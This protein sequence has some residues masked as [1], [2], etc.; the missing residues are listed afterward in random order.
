MKINDI[1]EVKIIGIDHYGRG[2]GKID[3]SV[4]FIP[5]ALENE[6]VTVKITNIKKKYLEGEIIS[7]NN[8]NLNRLKPNC[9]YFYECGGCDLMHMNYQHQLLYKENKVKEIM[10]KF[11]GIDSECVK[12]I[13]GADNCFN[14][15]NKTTFQVNK[16]IGFYKK[17]SYD[18]VQIDSCLISD[19]RIN[20]IIKLIKG[21]I[22]LDNINQIIIRSC[23]NT[24]NIMVIFSCDGNID[25]TKIIKL[26]SN[27]VTSIIKRINNKYITLKGSDYIVEK[28]GDLSFIISPDSFFQVNTYQTIKLYN[29]VVEY[30][31]LSGNEKILDLYCGTG[32]IGLYLSHYCK[33]VVGIEINKDAIKDAFKNK[34]I[35][36][37]NNVDF[38]CGDVSTIINNIEFKPDIVIVDPPRS[39]L[40]KNTIN[41]LIK[42]N[43][44][45]IIY[46]S[47]DS[48]TLA[49]DLNLL[50]EKYK[51][52]EITPVDM[53]VNTYHVETVVLMSRVEK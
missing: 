7:F 33:E 24:D 6:M 34:E 37:I 48:V 50:K 5:Y 14:Y 47:C 1:I 18:I 9:S 15:R 35:N 42:I 17:K 23:K 27:Q 2:I 36:N 53:F 31:K 41:Q 10:K 3:N 38:Q 52:N 45:K 30:A 39:G 19:E 16:K 13:I 43:P 21:N 12:G 40:D 4:I 22:E 8:Y 51:I 28:L 46:I 26:L 49:R 20:Q 29:K 11:A 32:T 44:K 25:E